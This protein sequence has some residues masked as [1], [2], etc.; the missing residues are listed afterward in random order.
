M[1]KKLLLAFSTC[2]ALSSF[3]AVDVNKATEADL[4]SVKGVG[5]ATSKQII[6]ERKKSEFKDWEDFMTRIKGIGDSK[7]SKL[8]TQGLT[9]NGAS[10]KGAGSAA[11][12][13]AKPAK[14]STN[15]GAGKK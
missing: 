1:F 6:A 14:Q 13:T 3:A 9:V 4:D 15:E 5:P 10:F 11:V 8:S 12:A 2:V 7:A